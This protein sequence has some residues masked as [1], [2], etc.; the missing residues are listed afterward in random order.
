VSG[1]QHDNFSKVAKSVLP[2]GLAKKQFTD[3]PYFHN[4][5]PF[6]PSRFSIDF[7]I[8]GVYWPDLATFLK[9]CQIYAPAQFGEEP[10]I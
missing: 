6:S 5:T 1:G 7:G 3:C 2:L 8:N 9:S 4:R 10:N